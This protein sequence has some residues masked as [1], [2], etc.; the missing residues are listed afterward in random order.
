MTRKKILIADQNEDFLCLIRSYL[1]D[2]SHQ[3]IEA[4]DGRAAHRLIMEEK[5]DLAILDLALPS[6]QGDE[7][8][9]LVGL[10]TGRMPLPVILMI[11]HH[12]PEL[13]HRCRAAGCSETLFKPFGRQELLD[14]TAPLIGIDPT[15]RSEPRF[16]GEWPVRFGTTPACLRGGYSVDLSTGGMFLH[17]SQLHTTG[18]LLYVNFMLPNRHTPIFCRARVAWVNYSSQGKK[19]AYP[20][21]MGLQFSGLP[22]EQKEAIG[23]FLDSISLETFH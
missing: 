5:P 11:E 17:T 14:A 9:H 1:A 6:L 22:Q 21:G 2:D 12:R 4:R 3:L 15:V 20:S 23:D 19:P 13:L 18:T 8:C 10:Q 7:C 16:S